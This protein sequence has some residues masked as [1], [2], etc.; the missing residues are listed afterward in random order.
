MSQMTN[1]ERAAFEARVKEHNYAL[2]IQLEAELAPLRVQLDQIQGLAGGLI[3]TD[4]SELLRI[5]DVLVANAS[6]F[7]SMLDYHV[8]NTISGVTEAHAPPAPEAAAEPEA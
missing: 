6:T 1:E 8:T 7:K 2:L 5:R 4:G 3:I